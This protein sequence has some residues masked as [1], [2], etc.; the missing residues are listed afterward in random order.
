VTFSEILI[1]CVFLKFEILQKEKDLIG[2]FQE[3]ERSESRKMS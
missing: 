2:T 3:K 1:K